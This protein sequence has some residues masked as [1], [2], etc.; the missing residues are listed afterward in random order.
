MTDT[1]SPN[2]QLGIETLEAA[3]AN[4]RE[5]CDRLLRVHAEDDTAQHNEELGLEESH[6]ENLANEH[7]NYARDLDTAIEALNLVSRVGMNALR[8]LAHVAPPLVA[9]GPPLL[10][11]D[12]LATVSGRILEATG[13]DE[14]IT[15]TFDDTSFLEIRGEH[16]TTLGL[17]MLLPAPSE[18]GIRVPTRTREQMIDG[19]RGQQVRRAFVASPA[20]HVIEFTDDTTFIVYGDEDNEILAELVPPPATS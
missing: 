16:G 19:L 15:L 8:K 12:A 9:G 6:Y 2:F 7:G 17:K 4:Q 1:T 3:A 20:K 5:E 10:D 18:T 11:E 13:E 14:V